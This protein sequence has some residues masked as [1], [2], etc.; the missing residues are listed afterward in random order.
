M[1]VITHGSTIVMLEEF[2]PLLALSAIQ[3]E[4]CTAIHGVPTMFIAKLTY[5]MFDMFD[6][7]SLRTGKSWQDQHVLLKTMKEVIDKMNMT[8]ITSAY[9]LT[10][11]SPGMTQTNVC[12]T[13]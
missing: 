8:E 1:A 3:K 11:T 2:D 7:S 10:E 4:K 13:F 5:P 6:M 9:G 12:D